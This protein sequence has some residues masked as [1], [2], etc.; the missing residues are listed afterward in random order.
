M[1]TDDHTPR[2]DLTDALA[3]LDDALELL[4]TLDGIEVLDPQV[5]GRGSASAVVAR[6][7]LY[8]GHLAEKAHVLIEAAYHEHRHAVDEIRAARNAK[9]VR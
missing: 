7:L 1:M 2:V 8:A 6:Q 4:D 3:A 9:K 5:E